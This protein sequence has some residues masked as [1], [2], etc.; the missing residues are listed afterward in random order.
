MKRIVLLL[1]ALLTCNLCLAGAWGPGSFDNDDALDWAHLCTESTGSAVIG[2]ALQ[3]AM[4]PGALEASV[5]AAAVAAAE[6]VAA[7]NGKPGK[8]LPKD[9]SD[10]LN[11]QP[12]QEI[13][14]FA[15]VARKALTRVRDRRVSELHQLWEES[16]D[17]QWVSTITEL[18]ARLK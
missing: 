8:T 10:W 5:G 2:S 4:Q 14:K 12:R 15:Q 17:K 7:A 16:T 6:L 11:R 18:E 1:A 13:V 9:L 3:A